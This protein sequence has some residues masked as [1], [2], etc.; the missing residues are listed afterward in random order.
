MRGELRHGTFRLPA[1]R[2]LVP[3]GLTTVEAS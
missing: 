2:Y 1:A 3:Q